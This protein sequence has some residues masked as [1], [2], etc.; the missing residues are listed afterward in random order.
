VDLSEALIYC[1][2]GCQQGLG[3]GSVLLHRDVKPSNVLLYRDRTSGRLVGALGDFG[4]SRLYH[5]NQRLGELE[6]GPGGESHCHQYDSVASR[7]TGTIYGT[8]GYIAP[9]VN[10]GDHPST[11]SDAYAFGITILQASA[12]VSGRF[13]YHTL[14][15]NWNTRGRAR[16]PGVLNLKLKS[17]WQ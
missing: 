12:A 11:L 1:H 14:Q 13:C 16:C 17:R 5:Q 3:D 15:K 2:N 6:V 4:I 7:T 8:P 9:E 10:D